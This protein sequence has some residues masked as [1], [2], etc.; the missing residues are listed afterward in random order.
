MD[1]YGEVGC[2]LTCDDEIKEINEIYDVYDDKECLCF[3]CKC[4]KCDHYMPEYFGGSCDLTGRG[5]TQSTPPIC[6]IKCSTNQEQQC[7]IIVELDGYLEDKFKEYVL[8]CKNH[9]LIFNKEKKQWSGITT[10]GNYDQFIQEIQTII[11]VK[12]KKRGQI[13]FDIL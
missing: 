13:F 10:K 8:I 4:T 7:S 11:E 9:G 6:N 3:E 12:I 1:Y 2:C 5:S